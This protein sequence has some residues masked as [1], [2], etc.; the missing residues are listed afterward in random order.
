M[1]VCHHGCYSPL[2]GE[3]TEDTSNRASNVAL[4]PRTVAVLVGDVSETTKDTDVDCGLGVYKTNEVKG[5]SRTPARPP[6]KDGRRTTSMV[7]F[8][9]AAMAFSASS[10]SRCTMSVY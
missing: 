4:V 10:A 5:N 2:D 3:E 1:I 9:A 7:L 8:Q 6:M